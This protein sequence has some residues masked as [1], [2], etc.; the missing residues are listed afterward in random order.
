[1]RVVLW[2]DARGG[3]AVRRAD[4]RRAS[5]DLARVDDVRKLPFTDRSSVAADPDDYFGVRDE[6]AAAL[7]ADRLDTGPQ[8]LFGR[9]AALVHHGGARA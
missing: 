9:L 4:T 5:I 6:R 7:R 3:S 2:T 1:M 8:A